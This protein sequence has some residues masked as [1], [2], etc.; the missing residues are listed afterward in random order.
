QKSLARGGLVSDRDAP[1]V[2]TRIAP[3]IEVT[4][5]VT[6]GSID[7]SRDEPLLILEG[8]DGRR[9]VVPQTA[10][11]IAARGDG[12]LRSGSVVTLRGGATTSGGT[13]AVRVEILEHGSLRDLRRADAAS[14]ILDLDALR[15]V[16]ETGALP[17]PAPD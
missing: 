15:S 2:L 13:R 11:I 7:E 9:H 5:R 8:T 10:E 17:S 4:G 1:V 12:H 6:G 3:G 14:T 16:R